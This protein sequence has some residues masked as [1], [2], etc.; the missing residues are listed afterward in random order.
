MTPPVESAP[1]P[2]AYTPESRKP[3]VPLQSTSAVGI[4]AFTRVSRARRALRHALVQ[5]R[6]PNQR[7][8]P[9][10]PPAVADPCAD[11]PCDARS[12]GGRTGKRSR[13]AWQPADGG[14]AVTRRRSAIDPARMKSA[15]R[16]EAGTLSDALETARVL[17]EMVDHLIAVLILLRVPID[18]IRE[19]LPDNVAA[20][21]RKQLGSG[22]PPGFLAAYRSARPD[23]GPARLAASDI[24][25]QLHGSRGR[26]V[27][28][29]IFATAAQADGAVEFRAPD[30]VRELSVDDPQIDREKVR[31]ALVRLTELG[32]MRTNGSGG[33]VLTTA[34][35]TASPLPEPD[36]G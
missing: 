17:T 15:L 27:W 14:D 24:A 19:L 10:R 8:S 18:E 9:E 33:Y 36:D 13:P 16:I 4:W 11:L 31:R 35:D 29:R 34:V 22:P 7:C 5:H 6:Q 2:A 21:R 30:L 26:L 23:A 32:A 1:R 12:H 25:Q 3:T 28:Q 20:P